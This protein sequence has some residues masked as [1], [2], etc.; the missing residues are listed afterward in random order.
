MRDKFLFSNDQTLTSLSGTGEISTNIWDL[1]ENVVADQQV[2]GCLM[3]TILAATLTSGLTEGLIV[4]LR[5]DD[6][7]GLATAQNGTSAGFKDIVMKHILKEEIVV[8]RTF[9]IPVMDAVS[10]K[11]LG[12]WFKAKTTALVGNIHVEV[13]FTEDPDD[14]QKKIQKKPV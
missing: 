5:T 4:G 3:I 11:Y 10:K 14:I 8:G 6:A 9:A 1:E 7:V 12:A 13:Y 2:K